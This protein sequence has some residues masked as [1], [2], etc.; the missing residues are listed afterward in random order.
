MKANELRA[1]DDAQLREKLA[2]YKVELFNLRFQKAT[3]KL[4]NTARPRLVK[5]EIA[6]ILTILRERELAQAE[7]G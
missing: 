1:L 3:G 2:E 4:T 6:R 5:K 7:L